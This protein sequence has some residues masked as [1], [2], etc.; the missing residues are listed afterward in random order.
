MCI[1]I[2]M[3]SALQT[4]PSHAAPLPRWLSEIGASDLND[5]LSRFG[6]RFDTD[7]SQDYV[8]ASQIHSARV[9]AALRRNTIATQAHPGADLDAKIVFDSHIQWPGSLGLPNSW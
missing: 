8:R 7:A 3:V 1:V 4:S 5:P 2:V 9:D 6:R